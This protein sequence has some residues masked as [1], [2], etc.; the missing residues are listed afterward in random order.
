MNDIRPLL[1]EGLLQ[2]ISDQLRKRLKVS[3]IDIAAKGYICMVIAYKTG[4]WC[5]QIPVG[6]SKDKVMIIT[7]APDSLGQFAMHIPLADP[8]LPERLL[9][10][11]E[12]AI[13]QQSW[14]RPL[15]TSTAS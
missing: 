14:S 6:I 3:S 11:L 1:L 8:K 13:K 2:D 12:G 5:A 15:T 9:S 7:N 10:G 4:G